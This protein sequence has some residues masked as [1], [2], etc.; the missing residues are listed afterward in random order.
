MEM[1]KRKWEK[2]NRKSAGAVQIAN[3][4]LPFARGWGAKACP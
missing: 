4:W 1:G 3:C 2:G